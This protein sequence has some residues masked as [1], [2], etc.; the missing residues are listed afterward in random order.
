MGS[1]AAS[2]PS[3]LPLVV[4]AAAWLAHGGALAGD[5]VLDEAAVARDNPAVQAGVADVWAAD[6]WR[7]DIDGEVWRPLTLLTFQLEHALGFGADGSSLAFHLT[8]LL[9]HGLASLMVLAVGLALLPGRAW[10]AAAAALIFAVHPLLVGAVAPIL[11]RADLLAGLLGLVTVWLYNRVLERSVALLPLAALAFLLALLAKESAAGLFVLLLGLLARPP[12]AR[13]RRVAASLA[14]AAVLVGWGLLRPAP[15]PPVGEALATGLAGLARASL[16]WFVPL[17]FAHDRLAVGWPPAPSGVVAG[18]LLAVATLGAWAWSFRR[19]AARLGAA[20]PA[21]LA[22]PFVA[23]ALFS[24]VGAALEARFAYV[25]ALPACLVL[26]QVTAAF[27]RGLVAPRFGMPA[28]TALV[29]APLLLCLA[30]LARFEASVWADDLTLHR[31]LVAS[32]PQRSAL[33]VRYARR[34]LD[35]AEATREAVAA[36]ASFDEASRR[37]KAVAARQLADAERRLDSVTR[38]SPRMAAAWRLLGRARLLRGYAPEAESALREGLELD[39]FLRGAKSPEDLRAAHRL[40]LAE[41]YYRL[42]LA[43]EAQ[44]RTDVAIEH[45]HIASRLAPED[46]RILARA[47]RASIRAGRDQEGLVFLKRAI[48]LTPEGPRRARL[49]VAFDQGR[50]AALV[51]SDKAIAE[52]R[53]WESQAEYRRAL[54]AYEDALVADPSRLEAY[55]R[56]AWLRGEYFGDYRRARALLEQARS[57][58]EEVGGDVEALRRIDRARAKLDE[59]QQEEEA[60]EAE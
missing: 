14:L 27:A 48:E 50:E 37:L 1:K 21:L 39:P 43:F 4:L 52:A 5:W 33:E 16:G 25:F 13:G 8:N 29:L 38:Q 41:T 51:R 49:Q 22:L 32:S 57:V 20:W 35:A 10:G 6:A 19:G 26:G 11:G 24:P 42:G 45:L 56:L 59:Q 44:G 58:V 28:A 47:G 55:L 2:S 36:Q 54:G 31:A 60:A 30:V 18:A 40:E 46:T 34:L 12:A 3:W 17:G 7:G 15:W 53:D 23:G 9:L